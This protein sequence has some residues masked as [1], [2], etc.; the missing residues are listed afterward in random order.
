MTDYVQL[1]PHSNVF[2]AETMIEGWF[3]LF[4]F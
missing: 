3:Y 4:E 2:E 1:T